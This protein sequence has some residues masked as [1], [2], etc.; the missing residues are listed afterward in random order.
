MKTIQLPKE[1][2]KEMPSI[3]GQIVKLMYFRNYK[4]CARPEGVVLKTVDGNYGWSLCNSKD[5]WCKCK[6]IKKHFI[7]RRGVRIDLNCTPL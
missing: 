6:G 7:E 1:L 4:K 5:A 3:D 2:L